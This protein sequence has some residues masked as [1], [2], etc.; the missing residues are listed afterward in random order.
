MNVLIVGAGSIGLLLASRM[1]SP[2]VSLC[3][4][5]EEQARLIA[6]HGITCLEGDVSQTTQIEVWSWNQAL[7]LTRKWDILLLTVKQTQF[8]ESFI[9]SLQSFMHSGTIVVAFQNGLGHDQLLRKYMASEQIWLAVS[10][11]GA[12]RLSMN[13]VAHTGH[14]TI[15]MG[16]IDNAHLREEIWHKL[17]VNAVINPLTALYR[18]SNGALLQSDEHLAR[19]RTLF[20]EAVEVA[21]AEGVVIR[22]N[23]WQTVLDICRRT[24][25]NESS[26]LQDIRRG[27][28]TEIANI[29]GYI[30]SLAKIHDIDLPAHREVVNLFT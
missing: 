3:T 12:N 15:T 30:L 17:I 13:T 10:T 1:A 2:Q 18:I 6:E 29:N 24:A 4:H 9:Q 27:N 8:N 7:C 16:P 26:M 22:A 20:N 19:M 25:N 21:T 11:E 14:G 5:S 28:R 23:H